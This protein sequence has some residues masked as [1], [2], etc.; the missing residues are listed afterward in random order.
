MRNKFFSLF[1]IVVLCC[2]FVSSCYYD[3][4][5]TLYPTSLQCD[6]VNITYTNTLKSIVDAQCAT[7][8]C[9]KSIIPSGYDLSNYEGL[10]KIALNGKLMPSLDFTGPYPMPKAAVKLDECTIAKFRYWTNNGQPK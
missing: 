1:I 4:R 2:I 5:Q 8:S 7:P 6:T 10:K 3:H 9:H